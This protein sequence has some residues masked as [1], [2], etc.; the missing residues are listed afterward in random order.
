MIK[1]NVFLHTTF[2]LVVLLCIWEIVSGSA[3]WLLFVLPPPSAIAMGLWSHG[4]RF[5]LHSLVTLRE[6][7][8]GLALALLVSISLA[9]M[10]VTWRGAKQVLHPIIVFTQALPMFALAP[11]MVIWFGWS[12]FS[13]V[14]PTALM[15]F[16]PLTLSLYQGLKSV[17]E[18]YLEAFDSFGASLWQTF[19]KM[20][21]PWA[22]PHFFGGLRIATAFAG[23]GAIAGE[24]AG[25]QQGLG[26]LMLES[27]RGADLVTVFGAIFCTMLLSMIL[28]G[29]SSGMERLVNRRRPLSV[30]WRET[31]SKR[32]VVACFATLIGLTGISAATI[33][34]TQT[35]KTVQ[36]I[37]DWV[38]NPNHVPLFV[39]VQ[40]GIFARH[41]IH[42]EILKV[43]D[44]GDVIPYLTAGQA[45]V[46]VTYMTSLLLGAKQH[47]A[48]VKVV[49]YLVKEPLNSLIYCGSP[50][51]PHSFNGKVIGCATDGIQTEMLRRILGHNDIIPQAMPN[52]H[53]DLVSMLVTG[54]VDAIFGAYWNIE[55][56][57]LR[58]QGLNPQYFDLRQLGVPSHFELVLVA[59]RG[60]TWAQPDF[61][62]RFRS[63][64]DEAIAFCRKDP[65]R[66]FDIYTKANPDKTSR[67]LDW[68]RR[69]WDRTLSTLAQ[70]QDD[71]PEVWQGY[72]EWLEAQGLLSHPYDVQELIG[73]L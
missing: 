42:L 62:Q 12:Y 56:E 5:V 69:A 29:L 18:E 44:P 37:L 41:D 68:E 22:L 28:Y 43:H 19:F 58:L 73:E 17:P 10:M 50:Q 53:F 1:V 2:W 47:G 14:I 30:L 25:G 7:L 55:T 24:W 8:G 13:V 38:P 40:A 20:R 63:A 34:R 11:L 46:A 4:D 61:V 16:V 3:G 71:E 66:A 32:L 6:M 59:N 64:L 70:Q 23:M 49:G 67:T 9:T 39:G 15:T 52:I 45:Q 65:Q 27:R 33:D 60:T 48:D 54:Q 51:A 21:L 57:H 36:L 31:G 72:Y 35:K 26:V